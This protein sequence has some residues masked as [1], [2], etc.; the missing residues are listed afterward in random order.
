MRIGRITLALLAV[1]L[2]GIGT[3]YA[4]HDGGVA[5]CIGCHS[6]HEANQDGE[7][8]LLYQDQSSTCLDCHNTTA[9]DPDGYHV[10]TDDSIVVTA[11]LPP[12]QRTPGGDFGWLKRTYTWSPPWGGTFTE[13]GQTHGHNIVADAFNFLEDTDNTE[14]PGGSL[15][16][17]LLGC[18]S[19]HDP[20]GTFRRLSDGTIATSGAPII[21]SGSYDDSLVPNVGE[22]VGVY[23]L[24]A[25][26]GYDYAFNQE[27]AVD[28]PAAVSP[29]EYNRSE[30]TFLTRVAYG[31]G[32][33]LWCATCHEDYH[34]DNGRLVHV[35]DVQ[36]G[37]DEANIY[38]AYR[39]SGD[40]GGSETDAYLSLVPFEEGIDDYSVLASH[41]NSDGSFI[42][43]AQ[44]DSEV[45]CLSCHRAHASGF[46]YGVRWNPESEL[47]VYNNTYPGTD[48]GAP[49]QFARGRTNE[50]MAAAYYEYPAAN[51]ASYQRSLCNKCHAKD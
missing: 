22:A 45:M 39:G 29:A 6:M 50:E 48:N 17:G 2:L 31:E 27:F 38:N 44:T 33:S 40:T 32:M 35:T 21:G 28:P 24:L 14:A 26:D 25:G 34:I 16:A 9:T 49:P 4:F 3:S 46:E 8:L 23:R 43:G 19:C 36:F 20:H 37:S 1:A 5:E 41:A 18:Q 11:D 12:T 13:E 51:F 7:Y 42:T 15:D 30:D 10:A 47:I